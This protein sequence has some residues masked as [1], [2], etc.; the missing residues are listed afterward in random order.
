MCDFLGVH[1]SVDDDAQGFSDAAQSLIE[2]R[3][4]DRRASSNPKNV[5]LCNYFSKYTD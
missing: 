3:A 1:L 5:E 4:E 2:A